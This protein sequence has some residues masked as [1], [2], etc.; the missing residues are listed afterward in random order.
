MNTITYAD[1]H[2]EVV[3]CHTIITQN[4]FLSDFLCMFAKIRIFIVKLKLKSDG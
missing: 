2:V 4:L 3:V 1:N